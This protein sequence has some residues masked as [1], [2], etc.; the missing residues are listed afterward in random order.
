MEE[1]LDDMVKKIK[2]KVDGCLEKLSD[3]VKVLYFLVG[4]EVCIKVVYD[5]CDFCLV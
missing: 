4:N 3:K 2:V 5:S 1:V